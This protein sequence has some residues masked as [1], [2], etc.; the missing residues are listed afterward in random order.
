MYT[1]KI[2]EAESRKIRKTLAFASYEWA[3]R[4]LPIA[5]ARY[6]FEPIVINGKVTGHVNFNE[7]LELHTNF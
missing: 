6:G 7:G 5:I 1:I 4:E 2:I 3:E